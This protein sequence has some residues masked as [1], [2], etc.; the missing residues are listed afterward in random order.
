M[1]IEINIT[2]KQ[3][4][5]IYGTLIISNIFAGLYF[6][7]RPDFFAGFATGVSIISLIVG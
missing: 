4:K 1:F 7:K 6:N 2:K 3:R 5:I